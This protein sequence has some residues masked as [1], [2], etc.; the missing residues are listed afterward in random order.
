MPASFRPLEGWKPEGTLSFYDGMIAKY[1]KMDIELVSLGDQALGWIHMR[2]KGKATAKEIDAGV[3]KFLES[4]I[5]KFG[6]EIK[7]KFS[8]GKFFFATPDGVMTE[9]SQKTLAAFDRLFSMVTSD[10][11]VY[12]TIKEAMARHS[13]PKMLDHDAKMSALVNVLGLTYVAEQLGLKQ[14]DIQLTKDK[15]NTVQ[16]IMTTVE[17]TTLILDNL[18]A[19]MKAGRIS[20]VK[21]VKKEAQAQKKEAQAQKEE[22]P[23]IFTGT[24]SMVKRGTLGDAYSSRFGSDATRNLAFLAQRIADDLFNAP[25]KEPELKIPP[26]LALENNS[27]F[28]Q[29]QVLDRQEDDRKRSVRKKDRRISDENEGK[30]A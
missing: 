5:T 23:D 18:F 30:A 10:K 1:R 16:V 15:N 9:D 3:G 20:A 24:A 27:I 19:D 13:D 28:M 21:E 11:G 22:V 12:N 14:T 8:F 4:I 29:G 7:E 6:G 25:R 26:F 2:A 17:G